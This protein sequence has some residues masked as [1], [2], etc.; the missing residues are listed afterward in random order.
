MGFSEIP[1]RGKWE[2]SLVCHDLCP[3]LVELSVG[4]VGG[5]GG[6]H[7]PRVLGPHVDEV[8]VAGVVLHTL[9]HSKGDV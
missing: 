3:E 4:E 9:Y 6:Q 7:R 1:P 5:G 8:C 2:G